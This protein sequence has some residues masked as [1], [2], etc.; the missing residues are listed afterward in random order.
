[1]NFILFIICFNNQALVCMI[2]GLSPIFLHHRFQLQT[3][4]N[5]IL[6]SILSH[7]TRKVFEL[8]QA[9]K[10]STMQYQTFNDIL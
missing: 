10:M 8:V 9:S 1:M 4:F 7:F 2:C 3:I 6:F 5:V